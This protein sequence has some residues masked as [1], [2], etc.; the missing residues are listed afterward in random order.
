ML[1]LSPDGRTLAGVE[2]DGVHLW[3][4]A[5]EDWLAMACER[6][7]Y[8]PILNG[9]DGLDAFEKENVQYVRQTCQEMAW[10][11]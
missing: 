5:W 10:R 2:S 3:R 7:R 8:H 1:S 4:V 9:Q 11:Q 6:L